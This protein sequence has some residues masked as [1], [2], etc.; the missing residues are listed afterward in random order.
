MTDEQRSLALRIADEIRYAVL[1]TSDDTGAPWSS[2]VYFAHRDLEEFLWVSRRETTHSRHIAA[3]PEIA[4]VVFDSRIA[5]G[6]GEGLY[7]R[8]TAAEVPSDEIDEAI[9]LFSERSV[10][11]GAGV[12]DRARLEEMDIRLYRA[13]VS[14][15]WTLPGDGVD[16][17]L[18]VPPAG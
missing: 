10:G 4:L 14:D 17:R 6:A 5:V 11:D 9:R 18:P 8:A 7:A 3:R 1:A 2:P 13:Q 15:V 12:W 16:R